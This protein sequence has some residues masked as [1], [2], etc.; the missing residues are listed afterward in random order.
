VT[1]SVN[2]HDAYI[3]SFMSA[4]SR[5][6]PSEHVVEDQG[7]PLVRDRRIRMDGV[8]LQYLEA[9]VR[10]PL[11]LVHG[12]EQRGHQLAVVIPVLARG[13]NSIHDSP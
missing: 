6:S 1:R 2:D 13:R 8:D 7:E 11:L 4:S 3:G 12:H 9:G 5:P 10:P